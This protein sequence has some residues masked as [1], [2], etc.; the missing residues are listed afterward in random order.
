MDS[1]WHVHKANLKID[2]PDGDLTEG[3]LPCEVMTT[4]FSKESLD[5]CSKLPEVL[6]DLRTPSRFTHSPIPC[7]LR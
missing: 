6:L 2:P 4:I 1:V 7:S 3:T 5:L